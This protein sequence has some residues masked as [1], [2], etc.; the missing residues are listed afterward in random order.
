MVLGDLVGQVDP[1]EAERVRQ[2]IDFKFLIKKRYSTESKAV[3]IKGKLIWAEI[4]L[5]TN[6]DVKKVAGLI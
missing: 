4:L 2:L 1:D 6:C 3:L 5:E